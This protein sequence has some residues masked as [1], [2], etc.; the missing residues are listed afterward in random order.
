MNNDY[1]KYKD[2]N[3]LTNYMIKEFKELLETGKITLH[4]GNKKETS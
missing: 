3:N 2:P 4:Y 1:E